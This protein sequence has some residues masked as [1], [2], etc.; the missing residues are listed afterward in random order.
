L[1]EIHLIEESGLAGVGKAKDENVEGLVAF[2]YFI[3]HVR[4]ESS[5]FS[6]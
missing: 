6:G 5:H 3:P 4:E 1:N 2:E